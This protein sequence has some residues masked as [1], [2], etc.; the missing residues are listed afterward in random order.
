M[1]VLL[2][3]SSHRHERFRMFSKPVSEV[4]CITVSSSSSQRRSW[5]PTL[6]VYAVEEERS[7]TSDEQILRAC[8]QFSSATDMVVRCVC[9]WIA[10]M[11]Q[12]HC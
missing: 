12:C 10:G 6:G 4:S 9:V 11:S 1:D 3:Q 2:F 8:S 7:V 5:R